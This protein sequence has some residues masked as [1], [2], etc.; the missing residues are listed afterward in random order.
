MLSIMNI[1]LWPLV[2]LNLVVR[3]LNAH[4]GNCEEPPYAVT[5]WLHSGRNDLPYP[6]YVSPNEQG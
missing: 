4:A 1:V 5:A 3:P 2:I 6:P